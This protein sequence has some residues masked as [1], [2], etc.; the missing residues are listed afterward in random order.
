MTSVPRSPG[1]RRREAMFL[2]HFGLGFAGKRVAPALSLGP[3]S[4]RQWADLLFFV[5]CLLGIEHYRIQ[6]GNTR[7][8]PMDFYDYPYSHSLLA[9]AVWGLLVGSTYALLKRSPRRDRP[10]RGRSVALVYRRARASTGHAAHAGSRQREGRALRLEPARADSR[11]GAS[12]LR[13]RDRGL[14]EDHARCGSDRHLGALEPHRLPRGGV[15]RGD[16]RPPPPN[17]RVVSLS[18]CSCGCSSHGAGSTA[19]ALSSA[20]RREHEMRQWLSWRWR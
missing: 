20:P 19:T 12:V 16:A 17:E 15:G 7:M 5:F 2:G 13:S 8:T 18:A 14:P 9:L 10:R 3:C 11:P 6:P 1:A 4:W